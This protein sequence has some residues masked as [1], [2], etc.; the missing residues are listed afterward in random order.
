MMGKQW[1]LL[2]SPLSLSRHS[3]GS[4]PNRGPFIR[5]AKPKN[6][7]VLDGDIAGYP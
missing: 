1:E 5:W 3:K 4:G 2:L 6:R 7:M